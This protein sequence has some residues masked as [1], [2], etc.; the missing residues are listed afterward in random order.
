MRKTS[1]FASLAI[2]LSVA[3][4]P[5]AAQDFGPSL[6]PADT[7]F[8]LI[9]HGM[10]R[11]KAAFPKNP[12]VV[13]WSS[14][15]SAAFMRQFM[16]YAARH[17]NLT[18]QGKAAQLS[19]AQLDM[20]AS[21]IDSPVML[22]HAGTVDVSKLGQPGGSSA[23][24]SKDSGA[25]FFVLD[26]SAFSTQFDQLWNLLEADMPAN[27][28][29]SKSDMSG[30]SVEKLVGPDKTS[31]A[32]RAGS[33]FVWSDGRKVME[34]LVSRLK[35]NI[36]TPTTFGQSPTF[37]RCLGKPEPGTLSEFYLQIPDLTKL[38]LPAMN[39]FNGNAALAPLHLGALHALCGSFTLD[40]QGQHSRGL[41][42]G[43]ASAGG[44]FDINGP[45]RAHFD[46]LAMVPP[47]ASMYSV[48][49]FDMQAIYK[50][51]RAAMVAGLPQEQASGIS[52]AEAMAGAQ[53]GM[54]PAD[55]L[56]L[57]A[58]ELATVQSPAKPAPSTVFIFSISNTVKLQ[59]VIQ[60]VGTGVVTEDSHDGPLT[61]MKMGNASA[62][63][64]ASDQSPSM[65]FCIT[66]H[67]LVVSTDK[68]ALLES[69]HLDSA[70][71]VPA[72]SA[73]MLNNPEIRAILANLPNQLSGLSITDNSQGQF[74]AAVSAIVDQVMKDPNSK[75]SQ[76]DMQFFEAFRQFLTS[77]SFQKASSKT[78]NAW[79]KDADGIHYEGV[80]R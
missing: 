66:P 68:K 53:I 69:A 15:E 25:F 42:M 50:L 18:V 22:G 30:V 45:N 2:V 73:L 54:Q 64:A 62:P 63:A 78:V 71:S 43:D 47:S 17:L 40:E 31:F 72:A 41:L 37:S 33:Y 49:S 55:L 48:A 80:S 20:L 77:D 74:G 11:A 65:Y 58:G 6:A 8:V 12:M 34:D 57:F 3:V 60:K 44:F 39:G 14:P 23:G 9:S 27:V 79:W 70:G 61:V 35:S 1:W 5:A 29:R 32:A 51:I 7:S 67:F 28:S 4:F 36:A 21:V 24:D 59:A 10:S 19:P 76:E 56:A 75:T 38:S 46:T 52:M 13:A 26:V 16:S